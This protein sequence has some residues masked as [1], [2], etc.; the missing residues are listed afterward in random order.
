MLTVGSAVPSFAAS[1]SDSTAAAAA[2]DDPR[3][4]TNRAEIEDLIKAA[5]ALE[6]APT[7]ELL[8]L[9]DQQFVLALWRAAKDDTH[10]QAQALRAFISE[11]PNAAYNFIVVG[12]YNALHDDAL[13]EIE[14]ERAKAL[15]RSCA[16][17][18]RMDAKDVPTLVE[19]SDDDFIFA[20]WQRAAEGSEVRA[21]AEHAIR[22]GSTQQDWTA[23]LTTEGPAAADRDVDIEIAKATEAEAEKIR[24]E[25]LKNAKRSLL[26][27]L[28]LPVSEEVVNAPNRQFTLTVKDS[29]KGKEVQL[30]AQAALNAPDADVAKALRDF[31]FTEGAAAN[32]RDEKVAAAKELSD[33]SKKV[34][35]ILDAA[36][37]SGFQ[38]NVAAAALKALTDATTLSLQTF[39]LKDLDVAL[40][41][42]VKARGNITLMYGYDDKSIAPFTFTTG[43]TGQF[44]PRSGWKSAANLYDLTRT[45]VVRGDFNGD[46]LVDQAV[47]NGAA[48]GTLSVDTF[49]SKADGTY[50]PALRSWQSKTFGSWESIKLT[51]G[52]YN[53]DG[54][55]DLGGFYDYANNSIG[56]FTWTARADGGFN[57]PTRTWYAPPTPYWGDVNRM[58]IFSGD[59]NSDGRTD[60]GAFYGYADASVG[61]LSFLAR[62]DG[63]F[64]APFR[65]WFVGPTPYWGDPNRMKIIAGDFNGDKRTDVAALY[66]YANKDLSI[67]SFTAKVDG[68][69][70]SPFVSWRSNATSWGTWE[71]T[72]LV[73]G[74]YNGDGRDD[75]AA[76]YGHPDTSISLNTLT[77]KS[78]GGFNAPTRSWFAAKNSFGSFNSI[79]FAGE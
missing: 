79:K 53:G 29:A 35:A 13:V 8:G 22:I 21:A 55:T 63:S 56:L 7:K 68:G 71:Q 67:M 4:A 42:D 19:L 5:Q 24:A 60:V 41:L 6:I 57:T 78:D 39:L 74:D 9:N 10:V 69:F 54:R 30:A 51:S 2:A 46:K 48:D 66:G 26:Q 37:A 23:F 64:N 32:T 65:S 40:A 16:V 27:L 44:S 18:V 72:R 58:K 70:N 15:R 43:T 47:L 59:F 75:L 28:Q 52:D 3:P 20:V 33:Y 49:L 38:P 12:I 1:P 34:T 73:S 31:V 50:R 62:S 25:Q 77:A 76:L 11:D 45:K 36:Q 17:R 14:N 61:L